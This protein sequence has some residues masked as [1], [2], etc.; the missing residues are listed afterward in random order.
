[1]SDALTR[2]HTVLEINTTMK[3]S[4]YSLLALALVG[5]SPAGKP[6]STHKLA[7]PEP[8]SAYHR[9]FGCVERLFR[10]W[11]RRL[12]NVLYIVLGTSGLALLHASVG[13]RYNGVT[14]RL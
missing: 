1:L 5:A 9:L 7:R 6:L 10:S 12:Q 13:S 3:V 11:Q 14:R 2:R 4:T 8:R